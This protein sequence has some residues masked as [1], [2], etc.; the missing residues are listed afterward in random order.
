MPE[1]P[2]Q[3]P[4]SAQ[5]IQPKS[6]NYADK[7]RGWIDE[8]KNQPVSLA[9][10]TLIEKKP[11]QTTVEKV[12]LD[13][14]N[15]FS[16][17]ASTLAQD[18]FWE[19]A[20]PEESEYHVEEFMNYERDMMHAVQH[21]RTNEALTSLVKLVGV[22]D[23]DLRIA[24]ITKRMVQ[25][26]MTSF[27]ERI[28]A[29]ATWNNLDFEL[30]T[31]SKLLKAG[32]VGV[33]IL[34]LQNTVA[35]WFTKHKDFFVTALREKRDKLDES[36]SLIY[37][38]QNVMDMGQSTLW[39]HDL[40]VDEIIDFDDAD[41]RRKTRRDFELALQLFQNQGYANLE[42]QT[43]LVLERLLGKYG[44]E[45]KDLFAA[46]NRTC[47]N[48]SPE[49]ITPVYLQNLRNMGFLEE[50]TP[51]STKSLRNDAGI[52]NYGR[53]PTEILLVQYENMKPVNAKVTNKEKLNKD[54]GAVV[55]PLDD[56]NGAYYG[57]N[58]MLGDLFTHGRRAGVGMR[59]LEVA[60]IDDLD[61]KL[62]EYEESY[63][64]ASYAVIGAHG[65][66]DKVAFGNDPSNGHLTIQDLES[67]FGE[68]LKRFLRKG[69]PVALL[70]CEGGKK[71]GPKI[72]LITGGK[73][74]AHPEIAYTDVP[75]G[76]S[77]NTQEEVILSLEAP[78]KGYREYQDGVVDLL[79][80]HGAFEQF[81]G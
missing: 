42:S 27:D 9:P 8:Q 70:S 34:S 45:I 38:I 13:P 31:F 50:A 20:T 17:S 25:T 71:V 48:L 3:A 24:D 69:A 63:G 80:H 6:V 11:V 39:A 21:G 40:L 2:Q 1:T 30:P 79:D 4:S 52:V 10:Y 61:K 29:G 35:D 57:S 14:V 81:I 5:N 23:R 76:L 68:R 18:K 51:G 59:V 54:Y 43:Y 73:V 22:A 58:N 12:A 56:H 64:K 65:E 32:Q 36:T 46:W 47:Y 74:I 16:F 62:E 72:S 75:V 37:T 19:G 55:M 67:K 41:P 60:N 53:Y 15:Q 28:Q 77:K 66:T 44:H 33:P 49:K 78:T 7:L 26:V